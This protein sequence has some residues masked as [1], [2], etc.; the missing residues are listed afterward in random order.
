MC[1]VTYIPQANGYLLTSSRDESALRPPALPPAVV[2]LEGR[3][4]LFPKD[5]EAGGTW[6][7]LSD[8]GSCWCLLNGGLVPHHHQPPY[9]RSRGLVLLEATAYNSLSDFMLATE[10]KGVEP[11]TLVQIRKHN[12][13]VLI[14][15][16][17]QMHYSERDPHKTAIW[18]S[19]S[20]YSPESRAQREEWF[21]QWLERYPVPQRNDM[22]N[23]HRNA[24]SG[25]SYNDIRMN[26]YGIIYTHSITS[27]LMNEEKEM[28]MLYIDLVSD[29][30]YSISV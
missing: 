4:V 9:A 14:W 28:D 23:F 24:G 13:E 16:G 11:F 3:T 17:A 30:Q 5:P 19:V 18:S 21:K 7:A 8:K 10:L 6:I 27:V 20:L 25:N 2:K 15:D 29:L 26:R 22:L 12:V 1:T